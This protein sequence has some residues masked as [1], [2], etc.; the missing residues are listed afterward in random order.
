MEP[1][2]MCLDLPVTV[3]SLRDNLWWLK[4]SNDQYIEIKIL[5]WKITDRKAL[6]IT[7]LP[8]HPTPDPFKLIT[9]DYFKRSQQCFV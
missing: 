9:G 4:R 5:T 6:E 8:T 1:D 7:L 3:P 2:T